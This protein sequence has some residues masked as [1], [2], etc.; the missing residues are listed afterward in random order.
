MHS[1]CMGTQQS[2]VSVPEEPPP[3]APGFKEG[4][5]ETSQGS[6]PT[7]AFIRSARKDAGTRGRNHV[8]TLKLFGLPQLSVCDKEGSWRQF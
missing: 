4:L 2:P 6:P 5:A 7:V 1:V 3:W 8:N